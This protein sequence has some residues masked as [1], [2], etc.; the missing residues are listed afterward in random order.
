[1]KSLKKL[2]VAIL[3]CTMIASSMSAFA[4]GNDEFIAYDQ[5]AD[6][7]GNYAKIYRCPESDKIV[8]GGYAKTVEWKFAFNEAEYPHR[9]IEELYLDGNKTG[10]TRFNG[11]YAKV[12]IKEVPEMW[13][14]KAPYVLYNR[15]YSDLTGAFKAT[16]TLKTKYATAPV[17]AAWNV[18]GFDKYVVTGDNQILDYSHEYG[19]HSSKV[20]DVDYYDIADLAYAYWNAVQYVD[21][22]GNLVFTNA[23]M[24]GEADAAYDIF[25]NAVEQVSWL[26]LTGPDYATGKDYSFYPFDKVVEH[27]PEDWYDDLLVKGVDATIANAPLGLPYEKQYADVKWVTVGHELEA[28]Y[29]NVQVLSING[30]LMDG[31]LVDVVGYDVKKE[32]VVEVKGDFADEFQVI[33][34]ATEVV[35]YEGSQKLDYVVSPF[36]TETTKT[37]SEKYDVKVIDDYTRETVVER[38]DMPANTPEYE[39]RF[40]KVS[41]QPGKSVLPYIWRYTG[42]YSNPVV[43]W[44]T[45]FA[46]AEA[47]YEIYEEKFVGGIATG[48]YRT[49]GEYAVDVPSVSTELSQPRVLT[50]ILDDTTDQVK[51]GWELENAGYDFIIAGNR[52]NV[53]VPANLYPGHYDAFVANVNNIISLVDVEYVK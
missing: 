24:K 37:I 53:I 31:R 33:Q 16:N 44:K 41:T 50:V 36:G 9:E 32:E 20:K 5:I 7:N 35:G 12:N 17:K 46:E 21:A 11:N 23:F 4:C 18:K 27:N 1:M 13:E 42:G 28:P 6:A 30:V 29:R 26:E 15:V 38:V 25:T 39:V 34:K 47:P 40:V 52:L 10:M 3:A 45:A 48:V 43:E 49:S 2:G 51:L 8:I 14:S 22:D 19:E